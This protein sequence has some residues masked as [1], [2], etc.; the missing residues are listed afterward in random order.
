MPSAVSSSSE[1]VGITGTT[2]ATRSP[3]RM[4]EPLPYCFS[5]WVRAAESA[6]FLFSSI[7]VVLV[8]VCMG[9]WKECGRA[10]SHGLRPRRAG[11]GWPRHHGPCHRRMPRT[12][13]GKCRDVAPGIPQWPGRRSPVRPHQAAVQALDGEV[14]VRHHL[15][16][17]EI[18]VA[19]QQA[20]AILADLQQLDGDFVVDAGDDDLPRARV[21]GAVHADQ[22]AVEDALVAHRVALDLEQVIEIGRAHV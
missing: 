17:L 7:V 22:V 19:R 13:V 11:T 9:R 6:R 1:P 10:W 5:I 14:L 2:S 21:D 3:M 16:R 15:D 8:M 4:T 18:G 12:W 20:D